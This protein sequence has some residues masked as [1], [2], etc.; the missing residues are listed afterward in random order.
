MKLIFYLGI[1]VNRNFNFL[2]IRFILN[3][4]FD[5]DENKICNQ[6]F[7]VIEK[8]IAVRSIQFVIF[9]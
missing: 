1:F 4:M 2:L 7:P 3:D 8:K 9:E 6:S 5:I